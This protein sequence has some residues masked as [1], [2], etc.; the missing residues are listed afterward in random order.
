MEEN[1]NDSCACSETISKCDIFDFMAKHIGM[2]VIHPGGFKS[3]RELIDKLQINSTHKI[4]DIACGKGTTAIL[5]AKKF[6]CNVIGIDISPE[7]IEEAKIL[8]EKCRVSDKVTFQV[9]DATR[10]PFNDNSFD[11]AISQAMLILV[12]D[13]IKAIQEAYRVLKNGG[14]AGW[15]ELSW[16]KPIT[17][18][19]LNQISNVICAYCM[20]NVSTFEE[21]QEIFKKA[22]IENLII[23]KKNLKP[24]EFWKMIQDEGIINTIKIIRRIN[25]NPEIKN[26]MKLIRSFFKKYHDYFGSG[27]YVFNK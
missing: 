27:I 12:E 23:I 11:I 8:A 25:K 1:C 5:I 16:K 21:W 10:L 6:G 19:I 24:M 4:I 26:R 3:T 2:S 22:G 13:K 17:D 15:L 18:E 14:A 20:K 7:L 9:G